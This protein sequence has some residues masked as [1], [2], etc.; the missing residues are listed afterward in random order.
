M[1]FLFKSEQGRETR[2]KKDWRLLPFTDESRLFRGLWLKKNLRSVHAATECWNAKRQKIGKLIFASYPVRVWFSEFESCS[3][4]VLVDP[5][6]GKITHHGKLIWLE[7]A[8][9]LIIFIFLFLSW[10]FSSMAMCA[11]NWVLFLPL[12]PGLPLGISGKLCE[13]RNYTVLSPYYVQWEPV[14]K[15]TKP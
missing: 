7:F 8:A 2:Q 14:Q 5:S 4:A 10:K 15:S 3:R 9:T 6:L 13:I 1:N 12:L 11:Y